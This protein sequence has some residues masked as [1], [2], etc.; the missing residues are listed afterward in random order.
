MDAEQ[1]KRIKQMEQILDNVQNAIEELN[2]SF[3]KF[4]S[5]QEDIK[6]LSEYYS[7][8]AWLKD[9]DDDCNGKR[10]QELKR[11]VLSQDAVYDLLCVNNKLIKALNY[12]TKEQ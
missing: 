12:L 1:I 4:L 6:K 3:E 9:Y 8:K 11:G 5:V 2:V 10:P 7:S